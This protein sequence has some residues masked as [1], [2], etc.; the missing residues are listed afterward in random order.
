VSSAATSTHVSEAG[1][2]DVLAVRALDIVVSFSVLLFLLPLLACLAL[3]IKL[4]SRGPLLYRCRRVG[5]RGTELDMLKFRKMRLGVDGPALT[6]TNDDRFTRLGRFLARSKL[7]EMPQLWN[8]L[9]GHMS[10]VGP[11]P[12]D[13]RFVRLH[14]DAYREIVSVKP[15]VTGY[16]QLAF[17]KESEILDGDDVQTD[18]VERLLPQKVQLDLLYAANISLRTNLRVMAWTALAIVTRRDVA[19][20]RETGALTVRRRPVEENAQLRPETAEAA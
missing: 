11:R 16:C 2:F 17:A 5:H 7:D 19:V 18:Y 3:A 1:R 14:A 13:E 20:N 4:E 15:G 9:C 6:R 8:V 10:L 12:E